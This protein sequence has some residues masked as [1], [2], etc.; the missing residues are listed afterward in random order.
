[1][2]AL[3]ARGARRQSRTSTTGRSYVGQGAV[4]F[5]LSFDVQ[6]ANPSFG[7]IVIVT[8]ELEARDRVKARAR[9][10]ICAKTFVGTDAFVKLLDLG[11]PVG[12]PVQYRVSGP[13][14]QKVRE[15]AQELAG[16]DRRAIRS[17]ATSSSTGTSRRAC[18]KVDVLQDKAR[19]LGITSEDIATTLNGV[20]GGDTDH[21]GARRHLSDQR[22]RPRR[23]RPSAARSRR[24]RTCSCR[25]RAASRCRSRRSPH[26][27][28]ELEQPTIWRRTRHSDHHGQGRHRR[29]TTQPATVVD[30]A[31][32]AGRRRSSPSC[33][34]AIRS[35]PAARSR[36]AARARGRSSPWCR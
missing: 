30:A 3:R 7:Q 28:Y 13:D 11:P 20:V 14:I 8:K 4:R 29:T 18:V 36:R 19:Q 2:D 9:E 23:A 31:Q 6:P 34:P 26:F 15:L 10:A 33:R 35:R 21:A 17:S 1:M 27:R 24:C 22:R 16:V 12:R 32:A 25:A 5:V